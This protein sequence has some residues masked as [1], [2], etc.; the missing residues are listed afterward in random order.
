MRIQLFI[1]VCIA[2]W[3]GVCFSGESG[4]TY[5]FQVICKGQAEAMGIGDSKDLRKELRI[6]KESATIKDRVL[7]AATAF[8]LLNVDDLQAVSKYAVNSKEPLEV[9]ER[10]FQYLGRCAQEGESTICETSTETLVYIVRHDASMNAR[11]TAFQVLS[12]S[13]SPDSRVLRLWLQTVLAVQ[14]NTELLYRM[15]E[16]PRHSLREANVIDD[17][18]FASWIGMVVDHPD[19]SDS[20]RIIAL[21]QLSIEPWGVDDQ[22]SQSVSV[23]LHE[24]GVKC[25]LGKSYSEKVRVIGVSLMSPTMVLDEAVAMEMRRAMEQNSSSASLFEA[26][27]QYLSD[28][29]AGA[30]VEK[31]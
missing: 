10:A 27:E 5:R 26:V 31:P 20:T 21:R 16:L 19:I 3:P 12:H 30:S 29:K 25:F 9:R 4:S 22:I 14:G 24:L 6:A 11:V 17:V 28:R 23:E 7:L 13:K 18:G 2:C 1:C 8:G 15:L